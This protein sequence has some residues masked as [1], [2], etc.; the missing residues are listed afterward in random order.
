MAAVTHIS[1]HADVLVPA[2]DSCAVGVG[3]CADVGI[4]TCTS[5]GLLCDANPFAPPE[6]VEVSCTDGLDNDCDGLADGFDDDCGCT[7]DPTTEVAF[8]GVC[9]YLDGS[10]G[11]CDAGYALA[12]Q[13][14]LSSIASG[15]VGKTYRHA[16]SNN[17]CIKH[18]NQAAEGQDW[19]MASGDCNAP[20]PFSTGPALGAVGCTNANQNTSS[21]LSLCGSQ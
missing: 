8:N 13:S 16:R 4:L 21:Q 19:G 2:D 1:N 12:P 14:V 7:P 10:N 18:A 20:G 6:V 5:D 9:Y 15:F 17:C 11:V 3:E